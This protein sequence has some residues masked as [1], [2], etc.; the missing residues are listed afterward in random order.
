M[1][2]IWRVLSQYGT[3]NY[4]SMLHQDNDIRSGNSVIL[5]ISADNNKKRAKGPFLRQTILQLL[6]LPF[7]SSSESIDLPNCQMVK[8]K[9][10]T[11]GSKNQSGSDW[12]YDHWQRAAI[13][14]TDKSDGIRAQ[15]WQ[16][17]WTTRRWWPIARNASIWITPAIFNLYQSLSIFITRRNFHSY[18]MYTLIWLGGLH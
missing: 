12:S 17:L 7:L 4:L 8:I 2:H 6:Q 3:I 5:V 15:W 13:R 18:S 10:S 14:N 1:L 16:E 9:A 11:M